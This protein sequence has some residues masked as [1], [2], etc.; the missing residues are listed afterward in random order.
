MNSDPLKAK[1]LLKSKFV[2]HFEGR[3]EIAEVSK[4]KPFK[5]KRIDSI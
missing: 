5:S 4:Q 3:T 2:F 1:C